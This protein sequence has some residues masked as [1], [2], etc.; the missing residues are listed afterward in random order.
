MAYIVTPNGILNIGN[1]SNAAAVADVLK[2]Y[3]A[4]VGPDATQPPHRSFQATVPCELFAHLDP[5]RTE[6]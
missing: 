2:R 1:R 6:R 3:A 5:F 4:A